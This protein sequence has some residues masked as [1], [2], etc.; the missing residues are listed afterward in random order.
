M[1]AKNNT[2]INL[3]IDNKVLELLNGIVTAIIKLE[4]KDKNHK[5]PYTTKST[6]IQ[7]LIITFAMSGEA[8]EGENKDA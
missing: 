4:K 7:N 1:V 5:G 2:R 3:T 8:E 6:F